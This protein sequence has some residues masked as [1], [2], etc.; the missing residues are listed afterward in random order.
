MLLSVPHKELEFN[1]PE[2]PPIFPATQLGGARKERMDDNE[3]NP[4]P[5]ATRLNRRN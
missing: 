3:P 2:F 4:Q 1:K 5:L